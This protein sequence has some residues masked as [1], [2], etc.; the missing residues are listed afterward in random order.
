[1]TSPSIPLTTSNP[2]SMSAGPSTKTSM[3]ADPSH[4]LSS[5]ATTDASFF[6][7]G[8]AIAS[9]IA[10]S[11]NMTLPSAA[12]TSAPK[13][14]L[15]TGKKD[16]NKGAIAGE[17]IAGVLIFLIFSTLIFWW[18]RRRRRSHTAPSAAYIAT[19]GT[20]RPPTMMSYRPPLG[21]SV[22]RTSSVDSNSVV[23]QVRNLSPISAVRTDQL[24]AG[25]RSSSRSSN[26]RGSLAL[27]RHKSA[28]VISSLYA[29]INYQRF[30]FNSQLQ[31]LPF[32][33]FIYNYLDQSII[34]HEVVVN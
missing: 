20:S 16:S 24:F 21:R 34:F 17:T 9:T 31:H 3:P 14:Q 22:S 25:R 33:K 27:I 32:P 1:M 30:E 26:L 2:S 8:S 15:S 5:S 10:V 7:A 13:N 29:C 4:L 28:A 11:Q 12:P 18:L 19:Y 23:I 6:T